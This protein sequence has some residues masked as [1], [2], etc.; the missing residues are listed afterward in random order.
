MWQN[1]VLQNNY[2]TRCR[3]LG[4]AARPGLSSSSCEDSESSLKDCWEPRWAK[5]DVGRER[6]RGTRNSSVVWSLRHSSPRK[7]RTAQ[8]TGHIC[9]G[10]L[11]WVL[12]TPRLR[13]NVSIEWSFQSIP[14][15]LKDVKTLTVHASTRLSRARTAITTPFLTIKQDK[16]YDN[17]VMRLNHL[18]SFPWNCVTISMFL[19]CSSVLD[20]F[21]FDVLSFCRRLS[22]HGLLS[23]KTPEIKTSHKWNNGALAFHPDCF[24]P[25]SWSH[26]RFF[27]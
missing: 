16:N 6:C 10:C 3:F 12:T 18:Q 5:G 20:G 11:R 14:K 21:F 4:W 17:R 1:K 2:R 9:A 15:W 13:V 8:K 25:Y 26:G 24:I 7:W 23:T 22:H 27:P 19:S